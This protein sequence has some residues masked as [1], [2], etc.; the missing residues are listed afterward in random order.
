MTKI[1]ILYCF[2]YFCSLL[3]FL[4]LLLPRSLH[5]SRNFSPAG[6]F[7]KTDPAQIKVPHVTGFPAALPTP[8]DLPGGKFGIL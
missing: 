4:S 8:P 1:R 5:H 3:P 7:P 2:Y 6:Q